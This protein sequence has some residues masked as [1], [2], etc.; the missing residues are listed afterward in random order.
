MGAIHAGHLS[1]VDRATAECA[2]IVASLF[3]N[4]LQF[5]P[6]EDF[7]RYPRAFENDCA[8]LG[9]RGVDLVY[10]PSVDVMYPAGFDTHVDVGDVANRY[11]GALRPGHFRGV[12][13]VVLK[14]LEAIGPD[15]VYFGQKDA[16]Q[17]AV[18]AAMLR[19]FDMPIRMT[20]C[21]T[22]R[23]PD[24]LA[25]SS[26]N[27]YLT[28]EERTA[29][30]SLYAALSAMRDA[31]RGGETLRKRAIALGRAQLVAPAKEAYLDVIDPATFAARDPIVRPCTLI[32]SVQLG[33]TRII[34]NIPVLLD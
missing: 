14:L 10:A 18:V 29:A 17:C 1:L 4:P 2:T 9:G 24:G 20:I 5:G 21:P 19:D 13:T 23:E 11:E 6:N 22:V 27:V 12:A 30:P 16:Q 3:V 32:G 33:A 8:Q 26:R 34:D 28:P 25:L 31:I 7:E 15:V